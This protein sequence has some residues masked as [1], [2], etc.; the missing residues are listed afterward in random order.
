MA[1]TNACSFVNLTTSTSKEE[2]LRNRYLI[3][4]RTV[5]NNRRNQLLRTSREQE[6]YSTRKNAGPARPL[7]PARSR[8]LPSIE[9]KEESAVVTKTTASNASDVPGQIEFAPIQSADTQKADAS[10]IL[11][12]PATLSPFFGGLATDA[13]DSSSHSKATEISTLG[14]SFRFLSQPLKPTKLFTN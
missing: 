6:N 9:T 3:R 12:L 4:A 7:L 5:K 11:A 2:R 1:T 8:P 13:F 14:S 10:P